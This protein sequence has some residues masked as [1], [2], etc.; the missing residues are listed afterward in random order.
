[1]NRILGIFP[2][3]PVHPVHSQLFF[4]LADF[5]HAIKELGRQRR[6]DL[7]GL[8]GSDIRRLVDCQNPC[9]RG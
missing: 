3:N 9:G 5:S 1:M 7:I 6:H 4:L 8:D 2:A